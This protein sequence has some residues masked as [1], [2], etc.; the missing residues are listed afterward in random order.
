MKKFITFLNCLLITLLLTGCA[1]TP[2]DVGEET[3]PGNGEETP[4]EEEKVDP[5]DDWVYDPE[6]YEED[7]GVNFLQYSSSPTGSYKSAAPAP[8]ASAPVMMESFDMAME[9]ESI[10][11]S[12]GGAKDVGNFRENI[13]NGYLPL[14]TDITYEGLFYDYSFDTGQEK[15]C[16]HLFCPSYNFAITE[17]PFSEEEDIYLAVGLNSGI[18]ES[19]FERKKLNLVVVLDISGSMDSYFDEYYYDDPY[20]FDE[21]NYDD[22]KTKMDIA[23]E[24]IVG[25][26]DHLEDDDRFGMVLFDDQ[27]Y[28]AKELNKV[29]NTK[30]NSI[31]DHILEIEAMGGTNME[32]GM[33]MATDLFDEYINSDQS[34]YENRIIFLTDAMPNIGYGD[35]GLTNMIEKNANNNIYNT[36]IGIGLDFNTELIESI[37]KVKGSNYY[38][39]HSA[40]DFMTRMDDEFEYMVTPLVFDLELKLHADGYDIENVYGSPV[41]D[42]ATGEIMYVNTLFPSKVT[43]GETRGG[44]VLL[45]L[46]KKF[47]DASLDIEV[48]YQDRNGEEFSNTQSITFDKEDAEYF[49]NNGI[50]KAVLLARYADL[51]KNWLIYERKDDSED[52]VIRC[53]NEG[54]FIPEYIPEHTL[55]EWERT[56]MDLTVSTGYK[57]LFTEFA[58]YFEDEMKAIRDNEL[59][60][61][62]D[63]L[64]KL[65]S[66]ETLEKV[67]DDGWLYD[68]DDEFFYY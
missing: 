17:D 50:R 22:S 43:A 44:I 25:L 52:P 9:S 60:Q 31:K 19:D 59:Q 18:K 16:Q 29:K 61:E 12:T 3:P 32:S 57:T 51:I 54:I 56:S 15:E 27:A 35:Y 7:D 26:L 34:E 58:D 2:I 55:S 10:G 8:T 64:E 30:M 40:D 20:G 13:E 37:S 36:F 21:W 41:A 48:S 66:A 24:S 63:L 14:P 53:G 1:K 68:V 46:Y 39:V 11:F 33:E 67:T 62:L 38:A 23:N 28:L 47:K 42:K 49:A 4:V 5:V 65:I 45:K 6:T